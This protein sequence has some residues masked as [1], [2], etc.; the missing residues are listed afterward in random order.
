VVSSFDS[1]DHGWL[2]R[3]AAHRIVD[4]RLLR[5][6]ERWLRAGVLESGQW[7]AVEAGT[8]QGSGV[9]PRTQKAISASIG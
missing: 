4:P 5:L 8:P 7:K 3:M 9:T 2:M 1:V 6:I